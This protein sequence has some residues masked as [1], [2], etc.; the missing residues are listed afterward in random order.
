MFMPPFIISMLFWSSR[1]RVESVGF[2]LSSSKNLL[3]YVISCRYNQMKVKQTI[4]ESRRREAARGFWKGSFLLPFCASSSA[5]CSL[6]NS[7][8]LGHGHGQGDEAEWMCKRQ[9]G[10]QLDILQLG[11]QN[12]ACG[13]EES[14]IFT[15]SFVSRAVKLSKWVFMNPAVQSS[16]VESIELLTAFLSTKSLWELQAVP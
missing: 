13:F 1:T 8:F 7:T 15:L 10:G 5:V 4:P 11:R 14:L 16:A 2:S 3:S 12:K 6:Q 9:W